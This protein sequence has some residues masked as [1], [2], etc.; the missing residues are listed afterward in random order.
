M[1]KFKALLF[2][3]MIS[4]GCHGSQAAYKRRPLEDLE[5]RCDGHCFSRMR[6]VMDY[7]VANQDRWSTCNQ[8]IAR[9][10]EPKDSWL[11]RMDLPE[12]FIVFENN[13]QDK[14]DAQHKVFNE[15]LSKV[16]SSLGKIISQMN[17]M[18]N[19]LEALQK[20]FGPKAVAPTKSIPPKFELIG[21]R[22]FY[23]EKD[24]YV[25]WQ[26]AAS[27]CRQLGG[28][29]ASIKD[30]E[31]LDA[32]SVRLNNNEGYWLGT[33]DHAEKGTFVSLASGKPAFLNWTDGQPDYLFGH[34]SCVD[35]FFKEFKIARNLLML[36]SIE[37]KFICQADEEV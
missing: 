21:S 35:F 7:V 28:H 16:E 34:P 25:D 24:S 36:C 22:Y 32:L 20:N 33:N 29:L 30:Q 3:V 18:H 6:T 5:T 4:G 37:K 2:F 8:M 15:S 17:S 14:L 27:T 23:I 12:S 10:Q 13:L 26:S 9:S 19:Q 1:Y 11:D 31:E